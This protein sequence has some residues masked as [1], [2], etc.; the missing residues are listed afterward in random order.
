MTREE[1]LRKQAELD[2]IKK[3][4][5]EAA[6]V[7]IEQAGVEFLTKHPVVHSVFW[8][9]YTQGFN[10]GEPCTFSVYNVHLN[11]ESNLDSDEDYEDEDEGDEVWTQR[12]LDLQLA[13]IKTWDDW[14][15][16]PGRYEVAHQSWPA[17]MA[18]QAQEANPS[19]SIYGRSTPARP[20][21][22]YRP[23]YTTRED[24]VAKAHK[25]GDFMLKYPDLGRDFDDLKLLISSTDEDVMSLA[26]GD[27]T[28]VVITANG[29]VID[30]DFETPD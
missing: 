6:S 13:I 8:E 11:F 9:Q 7:V 29:L 25:I 17:Q 27:P 22:P 12:D 20:A 18:T 5:R 24:A 3:D 16:D 1:Y 21:E 28:R 19:Y 23:H 10:D 4:M 14:S 2:Q 15:A 30:E 26:F